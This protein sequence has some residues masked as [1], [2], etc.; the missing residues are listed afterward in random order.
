GNLI[1]DGAYLYGM[2]GISSFSTFTS[3]G[4]IFKYSLLCRDQKYS[5][6]ITV[7]PSQSLQVGNHTY[8]VSGVYQD[9]LTRHPNLGCDS[10]LTTYLTVLTANPTYTWSPTIC[11]GQSLTVGLHTY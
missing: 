11:S 2:A 7:C 4:I 9:T 1:S 5:Q 3:T 10:I 8:N 6:S